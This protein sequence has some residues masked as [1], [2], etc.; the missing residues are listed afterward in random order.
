M[1]GPEL[2]SSC[3]G[4]ECEFVWY[5]LIEWNDHGI[6]CGVVLREKKSKRKSVRLAEII[7][8]G[9]MIVDGTLSIKGYRIRKSGCECQLLCELSLLDQ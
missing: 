5:K 7:E 9:E 6:V 1:R 4:Y 2:K 3:L 8:P